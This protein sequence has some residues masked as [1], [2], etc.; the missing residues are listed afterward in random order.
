MHNVSKDKNEFKKVL[1]ILLSIVCAGLFLYWGYQLVYH[2]LSSSF[3]VETN[4]TFF[5]SVL[6]FFGIV[7]S[8]LV[9]IGTI[10]VWKKNQSSLVL[11]GSG[12]FIIK[13]IL[14][15]FNSVTRL[16]VSTVEIT[17]YALKKVA[18]DIS[19]YIFLIVAWIFVMWFFWHEQKK[20]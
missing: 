20:E 15:I 3:G 11:I 10:K 4:T 14:E 2:L 13:N 9:F 16:S 7:A 8:I 1:V 18:W 17:Q 6:G 19:G 5:D 12:V